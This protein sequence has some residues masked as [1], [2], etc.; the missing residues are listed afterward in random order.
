M[1]LTNE[2]KALALAE[3]TSRSLSARQHDATFGPTHDGRD[4]WLDQR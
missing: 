2:E 4:A 1:A 3:V